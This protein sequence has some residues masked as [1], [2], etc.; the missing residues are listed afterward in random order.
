MRPAADMAANAPTVA[1]HL[2]R[3]KA[4]TSAT[5]AE[6]LV[7]LV[8]ASVQVC[9]TSELPYFPRWVDVD[10]R[11]RFDLD[12]PQRLARAL[13]AELAIESVDLRAPLAVAPCP[14]QRRNMHLS[15]GGHAAIARFM[16]ELIQSDDVE[17]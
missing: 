3:I 8:P 13:L 12:Q 1:R 16:A 9:E 11:S 15:E 6:L 5:G 4:V 10:D 17:Q 14:Y 7:A 2:A